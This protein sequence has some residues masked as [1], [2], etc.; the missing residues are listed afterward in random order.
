VL[1]RIEQ[2][3]AKGVAPERIV[4]ASEGLVEKL[5]AARPLVDE[6]S[7]LGLASARARDREYAVEGVARALEL[8][9][10][11]RVLMDM[12]ESA[13]KNGGSMAGFDRAVRSLTFL[14]GAGMTMDRASGLIREGVEQG[15]TER[16]FG[17]LERKAGE[18]LGRGASMDAVIDSAEREI[19]E[20]RRS[21]GERGTDLH[22]RGFGGGRDSGN[23]GG[24]GR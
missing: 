1:D 23:R 18:M 14:V 24:R 6:L 20:D 16:D 2:G 15:F 10:P 21:G 19:R 4:T 9:V 7:N 5:V 11:E 22:E 8:S 13:R 12:G 17:R 3:L